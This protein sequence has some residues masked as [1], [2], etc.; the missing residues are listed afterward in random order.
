MK[1]LFDG[2]L[3]SNLDSIKKAV[4]FMSI[5]KIVLEIEQ[6]KTQ[7]KFNTVNKILETE[8]LRRINAYAK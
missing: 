3:Y 6:N 8:Y 5:N 4:A 1:I 2:K 7:N